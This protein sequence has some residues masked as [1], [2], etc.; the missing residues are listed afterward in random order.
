[1]CSACR[2]RSGQD[3]QEAGEA[4]KQADTVVHVCYLFVVPLD[5]NLHFCWNILH[6]RG[7]CACVFGVGLAGG[8]RRR[9]HRGNSCGLRL[10]S[11]SL[12]AV[13]GVLAQH[14]GRSAS[15]RPSQRET[16]REAASFQ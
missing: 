9:D 10:V 4:P 14:M 15:E 8:S 12:L 7:G 5:D 6:Y 2:L 3:G 11:A 13:Q 16:E 1:M